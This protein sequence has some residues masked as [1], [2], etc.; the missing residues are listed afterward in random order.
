MKGVKHFRL[1]NF[2]AWD[3]LLKIAPSFLTFL[4]VSQ[5]APVGLT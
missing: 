2:N 3:N 1:I 5:I 4:K